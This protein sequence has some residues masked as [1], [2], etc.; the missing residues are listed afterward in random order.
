MWEVLVNYVFDPEA[1]FSSW[2]VRVFPRG[3]S[4]ENGAPCTCEGKNLITCWVD[5]PVNFG[6]Y[7][8]AYV[9][10]P[11]RCKPQRN[12]FYSVNTQ[13]LSTE[14]PREE[15]YPFYSG[16][17]SGC[18]CLY[19][20]AYVW[21]SV[22]G[23]PV[24][25]AGLQALWYNSYN[26]ATETWS[27]A[28]WHAPLKDMGKGYY[29]YTSD[30][31]TP[32]NFGSPAYGR[33]PLQVP[34]TGYS[35]QLAE[36]SVAYYLT[37]GENDYQNIPYTPGTPNVQTMKVYL[38]PQLKLNLTLKNKLTG[39]PITEGSWALYSSNDFTS[40]PIA[41]GDGQQRCNQ[42]GMA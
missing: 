8:F 11:E 37:G 13:A 42:H 40:E 9:G 34:P 21:N 12:P 5:Y 39:E 18:N 15:L 2:D 7:D 25:G 26:A 30:G 33:F 22:T 29:L 3:E 38:T 28:N 24:E 17:G 36:G 20:E 23:E 14:V 41:R 35:S 16:I 27:I 6:Y 1:D 31:T 10:E 32:A 4:A 19:E